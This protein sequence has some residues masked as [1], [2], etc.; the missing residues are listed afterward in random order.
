M[1]ATQA[2]L[3]VSSVSKTFPGTKALD[4][5]SF[6]VEGGSI[7]ALLGGNGSGKSTLIKTLAGAYRGDPGGS[8]STGTGTVASDAITP[9]W[10]RSAGIRFVHQELGL[11]DQLSV[12]ENLV[13]DG[14][15]PSRHGIVRRRELRR[16]AQAALDRIGADIDLN[17]AVGGLRPALK[18]FVAMARALRDQSATSLL[19]LD[20]PTAPLPEGDVQMLLETMK[21]MASKGV[22]VLFTTHRL[23]EVLRVA[24][25]VTA[26]RD[27]KH[28]ETRS[29]SGIDEQELVRLIVGRPLD[30][31]YPQAS[32]Q[33]HPESVLRVTGLR[34]GAVKGVSFALGRGEILGI[35]G[36]VGSGRSTLLRILYGLHPLEDGVCEIGEQ[37]YVPSTPQAAMAQGLGMLPEDRARD[38]V[39][40]MLSLSENLSV[41]SLKRYRMF[42]WLNKSAEKR[43]AR[44][45]MEKLFVRAGGPGT[46]MYQLSGG[47][48]QKVVLGRWLRRR[49]RI[50]LLDEFTSGI[51]VSSRAQI[52]RV[53]RELVAGGASILLVSSDYEELAGVCDRILV[54]ADGQI[55][56]EGRPPEVDRHWIAEQAHQ[57]NASE[58]RNGGQ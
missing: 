40:S 19:V 24:D 28:V 51:D 9:D 13:A 15:Y 44:A 41:A 21:S 52:Y 17:A 2:A 30:T 23:E 8:F 49:S 22:A 10:A 43:D 50:L 11:F 25:T 38:G 36:L 27:G 48:Q 7:H 37:T 55:V 12:A 39:F 1:T 26:L 45:D 14:G 4:E 3:S 18:T 58:V 31:V 33:P 16:V 20:E 42:G 57:A 6:R 47:N 29:M 32:P 35:G 54:M 34:G 53:S 5:V 46:P 56:A